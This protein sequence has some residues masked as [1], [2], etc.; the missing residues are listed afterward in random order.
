[1]KRADFNSDVWSRL[2]EHLAARMEVLRAQLEGDLDEKGTAAVRGRIREIKEL[3]A[4]PKK[5]A[6]VRAPTPSQD[7]A[8]D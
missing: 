5:A 1:M 4:L 6:P 2:E 3:L 7:G 8:D